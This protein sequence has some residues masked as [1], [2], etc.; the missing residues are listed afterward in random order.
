M[1]SGKRSR[2][3]PWV[4]VAPSL[5]L[6]VVYFI[7]P[8]ILTFYYSFTTGTVVNPAQEWVGLR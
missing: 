2:W 5:L 4:F 1:T 6:L 3:L 7:Y 8:T